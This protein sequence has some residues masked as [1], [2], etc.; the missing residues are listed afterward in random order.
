[1]MRKE[2]ILIRHGETDW[3]AQQRWQ[4]HTDVP[5]NAQGIQQAES[6]AEELRKYAL[7]VL[8]SSDLARA[9][10]TAQIIAKRQELKIFTTNRLR[11]VDVGAA[12]GLGYE[13]AVERFGQKSILRWRS[14]LPVDLEFAFPGGETKLEAVR[15]AYRVIENFLHSIGAKRVGIVSHGMLIRTF[16]NYLFPQLDIPTVLPNCG[17]FPLSYD[18]SERVWYSG[19]DDPASS[20]PPAVQRPVEVFHTD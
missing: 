10:Q 7:D 12:E 11:E 8:F 6:V 20:D 1:M 15:R 9:H 4:G 18:V 16:L 5:L 17:Y 3:N 14:V 13:E 2:V 19:A